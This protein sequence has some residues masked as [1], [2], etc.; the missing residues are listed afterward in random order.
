MTR[1]RR[2][3]GTRSWRIVLIWVMYMVLVIPSSSRIGAATMTAHDCDSMIS[4]SPKPTAASR[5]AR[6][7]RRVRCAS[8]ANLAVERQRAERYASRE[9]ESARA[10]KERD[11][12]AGDRGSDHAAALPGHTA[13][14]DR[15]GQ[16]VASDQL[17]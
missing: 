6:P 11:E 16:P 12:Q 17:G 8:D 14:G 7:R 10:A 5:T 9:G 2:W 3:S 15:V 4:N 13:Q 1:P